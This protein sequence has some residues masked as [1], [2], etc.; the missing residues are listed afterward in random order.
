MYYRSCMLL[1]PDD[2]LDGFLLSL[3]FTSYFLFCEL[4]MGHIPNPSR[5]MLLLMFPQQDIPGYP[6]KSLQFNNGR[7]ISQELRICKHFCYFSSSIPVKFK[8]ISVSSP[9]A[10]ILYYPS[11]AQTCSEYFPPH[12]LTSYHLMLFS[13]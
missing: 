6:C 2:R 11:C 8:Y 13:C 10:Q 1:L 4:P 9:A 3:S 5:P 12:L 7:I